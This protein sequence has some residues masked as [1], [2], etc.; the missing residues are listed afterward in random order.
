MNHTTDTRLTL[1]LHVIQDEVLSTNHKIPV[2]E[3][4]TCIQTVL[5]T[6]AVSDPRADTEH[7]QLGS[8]F[9]NTALHIG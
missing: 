5:H 3:D 2:A 6:E 4:Q 7:E 8:Y 1:S 9:D